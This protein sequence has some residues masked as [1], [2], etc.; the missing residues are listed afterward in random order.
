LFRLEHLADW[1]G[2]PVEV[3]HAARSQ[4]VFDV[5]GA[6]DGTVFPAM[7]PLDTA[8]SPAGAEVVALWT[9]HTEGHR[10]D[11]RIASA[12]DVDGGKSLRPERVAFRRAGGV[13]K[14][15]L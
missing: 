10:G 4:P 6:S 8:R 7:M 9:F 11:S 1:R 2:A 14:R 3:F 5:V 12:L 13:S 15:A